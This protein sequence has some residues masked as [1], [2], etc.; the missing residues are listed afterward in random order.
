MSP[1]K[2]P[3][4][5][6]L[7]GFDKNPDTG[8]SRPESKQLGKVLRALGLGEV[9][10]VHARLA[11]RHWGVLIE[12]GPVSPRQA[13][14]VFLLIAAGLVEAGRGAVLAEAG[15]FWERDHYSARG[16]RLKGPL[17]VWFG[18]FGT[19]PNHGRFMPESKS[20][21]M[22]LSSL[23]RGKVDQC[24]ARLIAHDW[25]VPLEPG[26]IDLRQAYEVFGQIFAKLVASG[27]GAVLREVG[28]ISA[29]GTADFWENRGACIAGTVFLDNPDATAADVVAAANRKGF[30]LELRTAQRLLN[31]L[32]MDLPGVPS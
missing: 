10:P 1:A 25:E 21:A 14:E 15:E 32:R 17:E 3:L 2:D 30:T 29:A 23:G 11:E 6:W 24:Y 28:E 31:R 12:P 4:E 22:V 7:E 18:S 26:P 16:C 5:A 13:E 27:D 20:L 19:N 8:R 9:S